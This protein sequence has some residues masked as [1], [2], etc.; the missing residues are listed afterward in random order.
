MFGILWNV[1]DR[2]VSWIKNIEEM[3]DPKFEA[4]AG[5]TVYDE[6]VFYRPLQEHGGFGNKGSDL[7]NYPS[8]QEFSLTDVIDRYKGISI[9]AIAQ[10]AEKE[11][12]LKAIEQE[13]KTNPDT[14]DK[15]KY[16]FKYVSKIFWFQKM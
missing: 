9:I 5:F 4:V 12:M 13:M 7:D 1:P 16:I 10:G 15:E 8:S 11:L 6:K 2:S 3:I 14:K